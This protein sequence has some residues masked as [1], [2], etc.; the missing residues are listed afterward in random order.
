MVMRYII[1]L[2]VLFG[3]RAFSLDLRARVAVIDSGASKDMAPDVFC[4][5]GLLDLTGTG[6]FD[7]TNHGGNISRIVMNGLD[8]AKICLLSIKDI[9]LQHDSVTLST[10]AFETAAVMGARYINWSEQTRYRNFA[11]EAAVTSLLSRYTTV[12]VAAGNSNQD[13]NVECNTELA[14]LPNSSPWFNV[15]GATDAKGLRKSYSNYGKVVTS[16]E[17]ID[18]PIPGLTPVGGTSEATARHLNK[19]I[20]REGYGIK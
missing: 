1:L 17:D 14:C 9:T 10:K 5:D 2:A 19:V 7:T 13:L 12:S 20:K 11:L 15:V 16:W 6:P 18:T 8:T 3:L 4:E